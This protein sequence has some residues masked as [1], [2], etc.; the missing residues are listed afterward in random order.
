M[1]KIKVNPIF[2]QIRGK[3]G[4]IVFKEWQGKIIMAHSPSTEGREWSPAQI[5]HRKVFRQAT[6]YGKTFMADPEAHAVYESAA[7]S[8]GKPLF[9]VIMAD[10]LNAPSVDEIDLSEYSGQAGE[11]IRVTAHDDFAVTGVHVAITTSEGNEIEAG[12]AVE[13]PAGSGQWVYTPT[14]AVEVGT[15]V[16]IA[17]TATDR[18][19]GMGDAEE[20]KAL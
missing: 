10:F 2:E 6:V 7:K 20:E 13:T 8:Q 12:E 18:A 15:T 5:E 11:T 4:E 16:R 1:A 14:Q 3:F 19:G 17:V 9:S